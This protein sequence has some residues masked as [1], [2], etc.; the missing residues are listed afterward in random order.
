M[1]RT[2][3]CHGK[4]RHTD[5]PTSC[6]G[7]I[8]GAISCGIYCILTEINA[9]VIIYNHRCSI[10]GAA[11]RIG[12]NVRRIT[13]NG[14]IATE[15]H[16]PGVLAQNNICPI[17]GTAICV[18]FDSV[19]LILTEKNISIMLKGNGTIAS[20]IYRPTLCIAVSICR[21]RYIFTEHKTAV[22]AQFH[23]AGTSDIYSTAPSIVIRRRM[24]V[25][26]I[27]G[28]LYRLIVAHADVPGLTSG[29]SP[30]MSLRRIGI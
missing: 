8:I 27:F 11:V 5:S 20:G 13:G 15:L 18:T 9:T 21:I 29:N 28:E 6:A 1:N 16:Y 19:C 7:I 10:H 3:F 26:R 24:C 22:S 30:P 23:T 2:I 14:F 12:I 17:D 25:C 4:S